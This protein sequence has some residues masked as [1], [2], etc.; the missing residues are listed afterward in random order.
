LIPYT[1][2]WCTKISV[3]RSIWGLSKIMRSHIAV[4][5]RIDDDNLT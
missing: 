4:D 2:Q 1:R 3:S 5:G